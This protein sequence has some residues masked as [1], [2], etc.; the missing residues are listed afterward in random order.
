MLMGSSATSPISKCAIFD[1]S[2]GKLDRTSVASP[3]DPLKFTVSCWIRRGYNTTEGYQNIL[4]G[5]SICGVVIGNGN[6]GYLQDSACFIKN[7]NANG[8]I[9]SALFKDEMNWFHY[10]GVW[11]SANANAQNRCR[12][13]I[14]G[15][16]LTVWNQNTAIAL[17]EAHSLNTGT[18]AQ[19]VGNYPAGTRWYTGRIANLILVDGQALTPSSFI[20]GSGPSAFPIAYAGTY[21]NNGFKLE[22]LT[23][24]SLGADT[25]GKGNNFTVTGGVAQ[26]GDS[27]VLNTYPSLNIRLPGMPAATIPTLG[28]MKVT[29]NTVT[30]KAALSTGGVSA[31]KYYWEFTCTTVGTSFTV[32]IAQVDPLGQVGSTAT[33][34]GYVST[35]NKITNNAT[36]GYGATYTTGDVI[37]VALDMDNGKIYFYKNGTIQN[38][39]DPGAGTGYAYSGIT[40]TVFP[41]VSITATNGTAIFNPG[42]STF[43]G[44][45]P[46]SFN[47]L[48]YKYIG[49]PA[50]N[51][52]SYIK[53]G[54]YTGTGSALSVTGTA[55]SPDFVLITGTA[56]DSY[57]FDSVN[58]VTKYIKWSGTT[59]QTTDAQSLTS[60]DAT[61]FSLGTAAAV[62]TTSGKYSY[63]ALK[64]GPGFQIVQYTGDNSSNK[65]IAH[66]LG[67]APS[68]IIVK[69]N[70]AGSNY[71]YHSSFTGPT[72]FSTLETKAVAT[73]TNT[74]WGTGNITAT[75]FMVTNNAT[76]NIN[77]NGVV[78]T[79]YLFAPVTGAQSIGTYTG[80]AAAADGPFVYT[81][82]RVVGLITFAGS[83]SASI[84]NVVHNLALSNVSQSLFNSEDSQSY[85]SSPATSTTAV[86]YDYYSNGFKAISTATYS[87]GSAVV[88]P[89]IA[90]ADGS[91]NRTVSR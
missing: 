31:G 30:E 7:A 90:F 85:L 29:R 81:R 61:G 79:A 66:T 86:N 84:E 9:S 64:Q 21:G 71:F 63:I 19:T 78:Y 26:S 68:L 73:A 5:P 77:A 33:S 69:S 87:N 12:I 72:Y 60:F 41:A 82:S 32:G 62:N 1:G 75:Q 14:N 18:T 11:D 67:V 49:Y 47:D 44:T 83:S 43:T 35:G 6:G 57:I 58:G 76:N 23:A 59:A 46:A 89:Y 48:K 52:S 2:T 53:C 28:D 42:S 3:T 74:P 39:G 37:G 22:F 38:S 27:P 10:L 34:W 54:T 88:I 40:G 55:F 70:G 56:K 16:E 25:S 50:I 36:A 80:N 15:I 45:P 8:R 17:N 65:N 24:G 51:I 91:L 13:Y 4:S 20:T